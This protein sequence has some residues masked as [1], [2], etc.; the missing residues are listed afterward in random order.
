MNPVRNLLKPFCSCVSGSEQ[1]GSWLLG[2]RALL[3]GAAG[4]GI[5][6]LGL[7]ASLAWAQ[8]G[9]GPRIVDVHHHIQPPS[10]VDAHKKLNIAIPAD[11]A[12]SPQKS[13]DEMDK[14]GVAVSITS[15]T[16]PQA[17][18]LEKGES[19]RVSREC[20]E[21]ARKM[22]TDHP[23]RFGVFAMLPLPHVNESL[24]EIEY[25]LDVL[26]ADGV[27]VLTSYAEKWL[28]HPDFAPV[29][30]ELNRRKATLYTHPTWSN[31]CVDLVPGAP[32]AATAL[33]VDIGHD[34]T[35][36]I[37]SLI[38][39]GASRQY[40]DLNFIFSHGG[41]TLTA[42]AERLQMQMTDLPAYKGKI[43]RELVDREL[44]RFYYDTAA[45]SNG[46]TIGALVKLVPLSQ[47]LF[48]TD[49]PFRTISDH[50][51]GVSATF[52]GAD[53]RAVERDNAMRLL[54][55]LRTR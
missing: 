38:F 46:V 11:P 35:R 10:W 40:P 49:Y 9:G 30:A 16:T 14:N 1:G 47:I 19:A 7:T 55:G 12:W 41:G 45:I 18:L 33:N 54:P 43:T 44:R 37:T 39:S 32:R 13:L 8:G 23:G 2:R 3:A 28:G 52:S 4:A 26:K 34:T 21:F 27:G 50:V 53:R 5:G 22:V 48:G 42:V 31:C 51:T 25:A 6:S 15:V 29:L 20:N 24:K 36:T 17:A